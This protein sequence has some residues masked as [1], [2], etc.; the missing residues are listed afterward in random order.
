MEFVRAEKLKAEDIVEASST[1]K[2]RDRL[3]EDLS[4]FARRQRDIH[5]VWHAVTQYGRDD[6]GELCLMSF[7]YGQIKNGAIGIVAFVGAFTLVR[8]FGLGVFRQCFLP[9]EIVNE[10]SGCW[11]RTGRNLSSSLSPKYVHF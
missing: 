5:D 2:V 8:R 10:P 11:Q 3:G 4:R 6:L 1:K 7:A 9:T